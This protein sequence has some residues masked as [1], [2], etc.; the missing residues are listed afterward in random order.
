MLARKDDLEEWM[1]DVKWA[2]VQ[3]E[4]V[5]ISSAKSSDVEYREVK[6]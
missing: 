3:D 4:L 5:M 2:W 6:I 1:S